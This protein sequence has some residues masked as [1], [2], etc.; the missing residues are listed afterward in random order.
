MIG[1]LSFIGMRGRLIS[2]IGC[3]FEFVWFLSDRVGLENF[4]GE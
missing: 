4:S 1:V 3:G 2:S